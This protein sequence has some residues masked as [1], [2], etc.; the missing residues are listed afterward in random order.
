MSKLA[1]NRVINSLF[2]VL[3]MGLS[4]LSMA[5][6]KTCTH[7][8]AIIADK[9]TDQLQS[10]DTLE[11]AFNQYG[12]CDLGGTSE[13][14]SDGIAWLLIEH[15]DTL[16]LLAERIE[17]N[18]PLK[19]FVLKHIDQTLAPGTVARIK[20]LA[21]SSCQPDVKPLCDEIKFATRIIS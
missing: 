8:Q 13:R 5:Q 16:P 3:F 14:F 20:K 10:W 1:F 9:L 12:Q 7:Q 6:E 15:W 18:P 11:Y 2:C 21:T 19:R 4:C 17:Q